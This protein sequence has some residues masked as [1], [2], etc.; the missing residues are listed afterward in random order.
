MRYSRVGHS[1]VEMRYSRVEV[2]YSRVGFGIV[3]W[4]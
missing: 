1:R 4:R 2:R 3:G